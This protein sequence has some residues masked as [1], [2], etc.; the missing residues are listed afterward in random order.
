[1]K[2]VFFLAFILY[3]IIHIIFCVLVY[4]DAERLDRYALKG[5]SPILWF[6]FAFLV[7]VFGVFL[8]WVMHYSILV[9]DRSQ[10]KNT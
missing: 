7:P 10:G 2:I 4:F 9:P 5:T 1:M 3:S 8:Y 6:F